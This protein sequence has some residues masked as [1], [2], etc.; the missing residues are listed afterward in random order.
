MSCLFLIPGSKGKLKCDTPHTATVRKLR[1]VQWLTHNTC[2]FL[3][4]IRFKMRS[5][6]SSDLG[7]QAPSTF[8]LSHIRH[9]T[10]VFIC[11]KPVEE[12]GA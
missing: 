8:W 7:T 12:K 6:P 9:V 2:L 10:S 5:P 11:K 4:R 3:A 1:C